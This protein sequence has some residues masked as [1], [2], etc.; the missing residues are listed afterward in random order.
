[1]III[2][3][4]LIQAQ[5]F[6][7]LQ[8]LRN[9]PT[10]SDILSTN[11]YLFVTTICR[12]ALVISSKTPLSILQRLSFTICMCYLK[13]YKDKYLS[14]SPIKL[15][16]NKFCRNIYYSVFKNLLFKNHCIPF[17]CLITHAINFFFNIFLSSIANAYLS[18]IPPEP[19][20]KIT[21]RCFHFSVLIHATLILLQLIFSSRN[22]LDIL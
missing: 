11:F 20:L 13:T 6:I 22:L 5:D 9:L 16:G 19:N 21:I 14:L 15:K 1:M 2:P 7:A 8:D 4:C 12:F 18:K 17:S 10:I 3:V